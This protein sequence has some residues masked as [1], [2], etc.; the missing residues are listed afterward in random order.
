MKLKLFTCMLVLV[1]GVPACVSTGIGEKPMSTLTISSVAPWP[2]TQVDIGTFIFADLEYSVQGF[3]TGEYFII[4]QIERENG[5]STDGQ[6]PNELYPLLLKSSGHVRFTFPLY[7][8]SEENGLKKPLTIWFYL[9][10]GTIR[11]SEVI[12]KAGPI[13]Y[14]SD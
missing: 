5:S 3:R 4:A 2:G 10:K 14:P 8:I 13:I 9:N 7:Y 11:E 12:A 6:Y 1:A